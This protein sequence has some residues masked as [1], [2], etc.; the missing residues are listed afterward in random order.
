MDAGRLDR[1][2]T[3][4][5]ATISKDA[6]GAPVSTWA[7]LATVWANVRDLSGRDMIAAQQ[8]GNAVSRVVTIRWRDGI[9]AALRLL[10]SD[11]KTANIGWVREIG[12]KEWIELYA[13]VVNE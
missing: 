10:F 1:R 2:V 3:L 12:R 5:S 13:E 7:D 11:G 6:A 4:Q 9:T 8:A